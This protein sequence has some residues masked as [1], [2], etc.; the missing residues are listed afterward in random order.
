M[1][2]LKIITGGKISRMNQEGTIF[3]KDT[4]GVLESL[5]NKIIKEKYPILQSIKVNYVWRNHREWIIEGE[6]A[7]RATVRKYN[8]RDRDIFG[9]DVQVE[10]AADLWVKASDRDNYRTIDHEL[11]HV[12]IP[13]DED[14]NP[15]SDSVGRTRVEI[16]DHDVIIET[17]EEELEEYGI[18]K[19]MIP[20][21][22]KISK[23]YRKYK[24]LKKY[25]Y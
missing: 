15:K 5:G 24:K 10:V 14:G 9:Y 13:L 20:T 17:F 16:M 12:E 23:A 21:Y 7:K 2:I 3:W 1:G 19:D 4:S 8:K 6:Y 11:R 25:R 22:K 18:S